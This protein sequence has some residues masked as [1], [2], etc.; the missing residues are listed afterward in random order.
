MWLA[1][2]FIDACLARWRR[3]RSAQP[4]TLDGTTNWAPVWSRDGQSIVFVSDRDKVFGIYRKPAD[5]SREPELIHRSDLE[6]VT[7]SASPNGIVA[8][9]RGPQTGARDIWTVNV[10]DRSATEF[11][12]T[13]AM[14][15]MAMFSPDG[16]WIAY[17]SN[18]S[19]Q[20]EVYVR[21]YPKVEGRVSRVSHDGGTAPIWA[22][23]GAALYYRNAKGMLMAAP[24]QLGP[25]ATIG[26][27]RA[28][29]LVSGKFRSSGNT[30]AYDITPDGKRFVMT[31]PPDITDRTPAQIHVVVNWQEELKQRVPTR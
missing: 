19:G 27:G 3:S 26:A 21:P 20:T 29:F 31:T 8:F 15:H 2:G 22:P 17:A 30:A 16:K 18:E 7:T 25:V 24:V 14:E 28:L 23:G 9:S 4:F 12:A 11:L 1:I 6:V 10:S 5:G 13:P